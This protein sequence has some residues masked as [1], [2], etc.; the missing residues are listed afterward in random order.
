[1]S[2]STGD[3]RGSR[4]WRSN[5][6]RYPHFRKANPTEHV[7]DTCKACLEASR[8]HHTQE[9]GR[10]RIVA[11]LVNGNAYSST[12]RCHPEAFKYFIVS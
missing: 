5:E 11:V 4:D 2:R 8:I 12:M 3:R 7:I 6:W 10:Y 9:L 1:M